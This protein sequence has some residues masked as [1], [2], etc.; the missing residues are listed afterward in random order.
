MD[1]FESEDLVPKTEKKEEI[2]KEPEK[3]KLTKEEIA[4]WWKKYYDALESIYPMIGFEIQG[5][6]GE[7]LYFHRRHSFPLD[8]TDLNNLVYILRDNNFKEKEEK[9]VARNLRGELPEDS[10]KEDDF[11][12]KSR[13]FIRI[14]KEKKIFNFLI[15]WDYQDKGYGKAIYDNYL[16]ILETLGIE[17]KED[18]ELQVA[19]RADHSFIK[20]MHT[21]ELVARTNDEPSTENAISILEDFAKYP[22]TVR[23]RDVNAIV[24]YA[25][26]S[27]V[28]MEEIAQELNENGF[29]IY[30]DTIRREELEKFRTFGVTGLKATYMHTHFMKS[31]SFEFM[32]LITE[33][34]KEDTT[35]EFRRVFEEIKRE[36]EQQEKN[37]GY[38]PENMQRYGELEHIILDWKHSEL[39]LGNLNDEVKQIVKRHIINKFEEFD[40]EHRSSSLTD[41]GNTF[42]TFAVLKASGLMDEE[43]YIALYQKALNRNYDLEEFDSAVAWRFI[44]AESRKKAREE[45]SRNL[46]CPCPK[47]NW[48]KSHSWGEQFRIS[49]V[50]IPEEL[51]KKGKVRDILKQKIINQGSARKIKIK[52]D[53][54][55]IGRDGKTFIVDNMKDW[56]FGVP[57]AR[58]NLQMMGTSAITFPPQTP[59]I[60]VEMLEQVINDLVHPDVDERSER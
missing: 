9:R 8:S 49:K 14:D 39:L 18:Y 21:K 25:I 51:S 7:T 20:Y 41:D 1:W 19:N 3:P 32:Q 17:D 26:K 10:K 27:N 50:Q 45:I 59:Q 56:L 15:D 22:N 11:Y 2:K 48:Q 44:D 12:G 31:K 30:S 47:K 58:G 53:M 4:A 46:Y 33:A 43:A 13:G 55:G 34:D 5:K 42:R 24:T 38:I 54:T 16:Q 6:E 37:G 40:P 35:L 36:R 29:N 23:L 57:G 28:S 60:V 52:T